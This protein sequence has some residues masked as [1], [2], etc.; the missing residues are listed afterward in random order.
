MTDFSNKGR[1]TALLWRLIR[2]EM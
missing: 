2:M 1:N